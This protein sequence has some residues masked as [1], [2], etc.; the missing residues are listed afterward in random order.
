MCHAIGTATS[1]YPSSLPLVTLAPRGHPPLLSLPCPAF[2]EFWKD[3]CLEKLQKP[4]RSEKARTG[5]RKGWA[6]IRRAPPSSV[7]LAPHGHH[8]PGAPPS[9]HAGTRPQRDLPGSLG[10]VCAVQGGTGHAVAVLPH[11]RLVRDEHCVN[12][13]RA[14]GVADVVSTAAAVQASADAQYKA[15]HPYHPRHGSIFRNA[16]HAVYVVCDRDEGTWYG[17][18]GIHSCHSCSCIGLAQL[19]HSLGLGAVAAVHPHT[20]HHDLEQ[21]PLHTVLALKPAPHAAGQPAT[22]CQLVPGSV[23]QGP[24]SLMQARMTTGNPYQKAVGVLPFDNHMQPGR[25]AARFAC[26]HGSTAMLAMQR[27]MHPST[28]QQ[29]RALGTASQLSLHNV[30]EFGACAYALQQYTPTTHPP[31]PCKYTQHMQPPTHP[32]TNPLVYPR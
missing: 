7:C 8:S 4:Q 2:L 16:E 9:V 12:M 19:L 21:Q 22:T 23:N 31:V 6:T 25:K 18:Q 1:H 20:C 17:L 13:V 14:R 26:R 30:P 3:T 5:C 32:P 27:M 28:L 15:V 11:T 10:V 29:Q 24:R